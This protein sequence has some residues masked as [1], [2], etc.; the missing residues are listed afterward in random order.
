MGKVEVPLVTEV[1]PLPDAGEII[2]RIGTQAQNRYFA[3]IRRTPDRKSQ[4]KTR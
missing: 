3:G 4:P 2:Q 1:T